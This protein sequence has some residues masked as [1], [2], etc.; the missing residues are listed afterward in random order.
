MV[1]TGRKT[2][3][4]FF[5]LEKTNYEKKLIRE[6]KLENGDKTTQ[7]KQIEKE[8]EKF[9][10]NM[11][12]SKN[13]L[14]SEPLGEN[15]SFESFVEGIEI[16]QLN[17]E[18]RDSLEY[19]FTFEELK[20][21]LGS[22][23]DNK[24]PGEDGFTKEF[25]ESFY[26]LIWRDLLNSYNAAF[27]SGSLF[28]SQRRGIITLIPKADGDLSEL[29]NWR[30][31]SLLNIDYKI[32]TKALAKRIEQYLPKLINSD[33]TGFVKGRYIG[34]NIRLLSD[35]ME[36]LN[37]NKTSGLLLFIDFEKAFD[38]LEWDFIVKA[39]NVFNFGPNVKRWISIFYNGVQSAVINGGFL[40]NYFNISRGVRQGCPLSPLL[41]ILAAELLAAKIRQEPSCRGVSLPD[42][43]EV[44]ISQFADDTT[45]ITKNVE[46]LKPYLQI[47]DCFGIISGL[48]LNK[49]KTKAMWI[50]SMKDSNLKVLDFK[51]T[52]EPIKV[53]GIHLSY[54]KNKCTEEN[55]Y[56]KINKMKTKLNLWL[57]RD[58][59][60]Y[61]KSLLAKALGI[62]Q[63]VYAAS[64]LTVPESVIKTVQENLFAFLWKNRKDKIKRLVMYQ[65]IAKGGINFVNF[66]T[67]V[68]SLRLAWISRLLGESDD[69]WKKLRKKWKAFCRRADK[70]FDTVADP[71]ICSQHFLKEDLKKTL[72]G[73][74]EVISGGVPKIFD[75]KQ[76]KAKSNLRKDRQQKRHR[77]AQHSADNTTE[78]LPAKQHRNVL[79]QTELTM[80]DLAKMEQG[81][82]QS[83]TSTP[84]SKQEVKV[85]ASVQ[86]RREQVVQDVLKSDESVK[87]YTGI[88]SLSCFMLLFNTLLPYVG[89]MKYWDKNKLQKSYYQDDPEKKKPGR[90]RDVGLKEEFI[91]VLLRLKLGLMERHLADMFSFCTRVII[92]CTE[93]FIEKPSS[94]SAQ[95]AT[96]SDY[97]HHNTVKL[98]VGITP[99]GAFSF[100]SRLW[101]R[102]TSDRRVTQE[103]GL[104]DIL[105]KGDEVMAD[106]GFTIRDLLTKRGVKLNMPPFTKGK[107]LSRKAR[108][109]TSSIAKVRIHVERAIE[110][111]KE[112]KVFQGNIPLTSLK[113]ID[114]EV[115]VCASLCNLLPPLAK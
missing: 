76:P 74:T 60:I 43:Q 36:Y 19:D 51:T 95:K 86:Q 114:Q 3:K 115:I 5:N 98:L 45:I 102:S 22:F 66:C 35:V 83:S 71:R 10:S 59:T 79:C 89:K 4:Y 88:P 112:F 54:N 30:P 41:F 42:D 58:L 70:K 56:V 28:I 31:I 13:N 9:Y 106:R 110:R 21:A 55:F 52:K 100:I 111:L 81:I 69:K 8:L 48:K 47:L 85:G 97:K 108:K 57:S 80:E 72:S 40:T 49:K 24:T 34:Q 23:S 99:S 103:S 15:K 109:E 61:G 1:G 77:Q 33:Q 32:L 92:D 91:L 78:E 16:P 17:A 2:H 90:K 50:G 75:P 82:N 65:P 62:S 101:S 67:V 107:Q 7:P 18:E 25:Y 96:W 113:L 64:M 63:L 73:K 53:L 14:N 68:K 44:K 94:P 39:L 11:Y 104:I 46:S 87:F 105:E 27:Q 20:E 37:A 12:T 38:S 6:V 26:D 29:S 84:T 93:F